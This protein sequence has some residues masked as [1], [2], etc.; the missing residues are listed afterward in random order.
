M[1]RYPLYVVDAS[2]AY[3]DI[4]VVNRESWGWPNT[5]EIRHIKAFEWELPVWP[6]ETQRIS[7]PDWSCFELKH[8]DLDEFSGWSVE[9]FSAS[10][11]TARKQREWD[12]FHALAR[13]AE[14]PI[15]LIRIDA[16]AGH[17]VIDYVRSEWVP[18]NRDELGKQ[19]KQAL[20]KLALKRN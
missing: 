11:R 12:V 5:P 10:G 18:D 14:P 3:L 4:S 1:R 7:L 2:T 13:D 9:D 17:N 20:W 15:G 16:P 19:H 6:A 8:L